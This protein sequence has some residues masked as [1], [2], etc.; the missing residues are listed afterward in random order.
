MTLSIKGRK[1]TIKNYFDGI[2]RFDF[3]ELCSKNIGAEDYIK[4]AKVC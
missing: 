3:K 4:I 1:L 2:A